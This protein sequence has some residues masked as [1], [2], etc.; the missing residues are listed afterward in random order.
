MSSSLTPSNPIIPL[1]DAL[2]DQ[3][4]HIEAYQVGNM[5][6]ASRNRGPLPPYNQYPGAYTKYQLDGPGSGPGSASASGGRRG[7]NAP[8]VSSQHSVHSP[9]T[10]PRPPQGFPSS[11]GAASGSYG[12]PG[13]TLLTDPAREYQRRP[14]DVLRLMDVPATCFNFDN[15]VSLLNSLPSIVTIRIA[16]E[17]ARF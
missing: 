5:S 10:S 4:V 3:E 13:A 7:S 11:V 17:F 1:S 12:A 15:E 8:S 9:K 2:T 16:L 6:G 14:M